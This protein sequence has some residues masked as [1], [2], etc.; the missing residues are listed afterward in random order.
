ME[1]RR[2]KAHTVYEQRLIQ[3]DPGDGW[4]DTDWI[5]VI[6]FDAPREQDPGLDAAL[7][8]AFPAFAAAGAT[9]VR[10]AHRTQDHPR[11]PTHRPRCMVVMEWPH[12]PPV[13]MDLAAAVQARFGAD[14][15]RLDGFTGHRLYPWPDRP[16]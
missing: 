9:R 16:E 1:K 14:V 11:N 4:L 2:D 13:G 12:Q 7:A 6:R 5:S 3:P 8:E 15:T 10:F